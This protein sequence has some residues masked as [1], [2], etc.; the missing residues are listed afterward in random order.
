LAESAFPGC[1]SEHWSF[2]QIEVFI[3]FI[4]LNDMPANDNRIAGLYRVSSLIVSLI[5]FRFNFPF[6]VSGNLAMK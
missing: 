5:S 4:G 2:W 1:K 6:G 3:G